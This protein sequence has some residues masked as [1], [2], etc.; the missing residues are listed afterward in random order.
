MVL[1]LE[2]LVGEEVGMVLVNG[3]ITI[4]KLAIAIWFWDGAAM[5]KL[6]P[7]YLEVLMLLVRL[8]MLTSVLI[9]PEEI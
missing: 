2:E 8:E 6:F 3:L 9:I 7:I 5:E 1:Y 4:N